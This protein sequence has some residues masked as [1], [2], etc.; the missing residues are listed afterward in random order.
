MQLIGDGSWSAGHA[1]TRG[2]DGGDEGWTSTAVVADLALGTR[3]LLLLSTV[4][5]G[6]GRRCHL[7]AFLP[8]QSTTSRSRLP[9]QLLLL[10]D[11]T[12][13]SS[14]HGMARQE[15]VI[16]PLDAVRRENRVYVLQIQMR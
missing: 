1:R 3:S 6:P 16:V 9:L 5:A 7:C 11:L 12:T 2:R 14:F 8:N 10:L 13:T 15:D 4:R